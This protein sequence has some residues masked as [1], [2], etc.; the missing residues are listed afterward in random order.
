[1]PIEE[2]FRPALP[3]PI[4]IEVAQEPTTFTAG[5]NKENVSKPIPGMLEYDL[6][7]SVWN[8]YYKKNII[9]WGISNFINSSPY[10]AKVSAAS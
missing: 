5:K 1:M 4:E 10:K 3:Q 6:Q 8:C 7:F 2:D 9:F